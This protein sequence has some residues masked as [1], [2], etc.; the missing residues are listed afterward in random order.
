[1]QKK[2][3]TLGQRFSIA[4]LAVLLFFSLAALSGCSKS[5]EPSGC[6]VISMTVT[7][8]ESATQTYATAQGNVLCRDET[9]ANV[10]GSPLTMVACKGIPYASPPTGNLRFADP[11]DAPIRSATLTATAFRSMCPQ[12]PTAGT[13]E[14]EDCLFLNIFRPKGASPAAGF[15]VMVWIHGGAMIQGSGGDAG[16][17]LPGLVREGVVVVTINYRLGLLGFLDHAALDGD[18]GNYGIKDQQQ[19]LRWVRDNVANFGGNPNNVTIFGESAGGHSAL[20]QISCP[21]SACLFQKAIVQ[22]GSYNPTQI[23][24][25]IARTLYNPMVSTAL[26]CTGTAAEIRTCLRGKTVAEI[27]AALGSFWPVP[28]VETTFLPRSITA[29]VSGGIINHVPIM[30]GSNRDEHRLFMLL[31]VGANNFE[32][33]TGAKYRSGVTELLA[34]D[35]RIPTGLYTSIGNYYSNK[36][37]GLTQHRWRLPIADLGGDFRFTCNDLRHT[38]QLFSRVPV[39]AYWF[40]DRSSTLLGFA[41]FDIAISSALVAAGIPYAA[42]NQNP[43]RM[44]ATHSYEIQYVF[45]TVG[46]RG[47]TAEQMALSN[48]ML[49]Y[50]AEFAKTGNPNFTGTAVTWPRF[51]STNGSFMRFNAEGPMITTANTFSSV[52]NCECWNGIWDNGNTNS[53]AF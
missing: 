14:S 35:A 41:A 12:S 25:T 43:F 5:D 29:A 51:E 9:K 31:G 24:R 15:P 3:G 28:S 37:E 34:T 23:T 11:V 18:P 8:A 53:C 48:N 10:N 50:W 21:T 40:A 16:Y 2:F 33:T 7:T 52:H 22:S 1:M 39:Y 44:L 26:G 42:L 32:D 45:G 4:V 38:R 49:K 46:A 20:T 36:Y 17:D 19:A 30:I 27:R 6:P 47:G 13:G